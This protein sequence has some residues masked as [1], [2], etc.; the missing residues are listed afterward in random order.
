MYVCIYIYAFVT[1]G[2][3]SGFNYKIINTIFVVSP[4]YFVTYITP[5]YIITLRFTRYIF[6]IMFNTIPSQRL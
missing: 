5:R 2:R 6:H 4:L 3:W 1:G